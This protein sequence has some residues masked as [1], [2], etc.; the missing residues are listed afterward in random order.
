MNENAEPLME[1]QYVKE[2]FSILQD[3]G[4]DSSGLS[5]LLGHVS[6]MESFV[7]RAEDKIAEMKSQLAEMKEV[8]NAP[9]IKRKQGACRA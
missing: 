2:L 8:Q 7:K 3:N 1:N 9:K 6:E 5:A 4:R